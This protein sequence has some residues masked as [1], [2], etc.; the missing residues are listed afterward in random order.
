MGQKKK[1]RNMVSAHDRREKQNSTG[2]NSAKSRNDVPA[3]EATKAA[4]G[5]Q[6]RQSR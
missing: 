1:Q 6:V 5:K 2:R 4:S 3:T